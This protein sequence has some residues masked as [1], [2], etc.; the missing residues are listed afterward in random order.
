MSRAHRDG[1]IFRAILMTLISLV[2]ILLIMTFTTPLFL[3]LSGEEHMT[4][5]WGEPFEDP[6][7]EVL[8][9][10]GEAKTEGNVDVTRLGTYTLRYSF[11]TEELIR[12]VTVVDTVRPEIVLKGA[13]VLSVEKG[14]RY[15]EQGWEATDNVDGD[16][17]ENVWTESDLNLG[18]IGEYHI[19]YYVSD[20]SGNETRV[21]RKISVTAKGPMS[22][23]MTEFDL[24]PFYP[25][26]I[27][28]EAPFDQEKY[29]NIVF[30]GDS[31]IG[32][33]RAY[34]LGITKNMWSSGGLIPTEIYTKAL[35]VGFDQTSY[36]FIDLMNRNH[37]ET[38][39]ILLGNQVSAYWTPDYYKSVMD[40]IYG[41]IKKRYP[42]TTFVIC[43]LC[44]F[45]AEGDSYNISSKGFSRNDRVNK[46]N[47]VYCELCRKHGFRFMNAAEVLKAP[48]GYCKPEW[49]GPD[50]FHL[51]KKGFEVLLDYVQ[52][53][54]DW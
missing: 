21:R 31:F 42:D 53:H 14:G 26:V 2:L 30:F 52:K 38:V 8:F 36:T 44:P 19:S 23:S 12:T 9:G 39:V 37:P 48:N 32:Y 49:M 16:L 29:E 11:L 3:K 50:Y 20:S 15:V 27:C 6:G 25:D 33:L 40:N 51:N 7:A 4:A 5:E 46:I 43:S 28:G 1:Y 22:Q 10:L 13:S 24:D 45:S 34:N 54:M 18:E 17:S 47:A 41:D 35:E